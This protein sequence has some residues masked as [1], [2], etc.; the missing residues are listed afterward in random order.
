MLA[1]HFKELCV[2]SSL[3]VVASQM[4]ATPLKLISHIWICLA[5][6]QKSDKLLQV[7]IKELSLQSK[8][9]IVIYVI[10]ICTEVLNEI[11]S[12]IEALIGVQV[13]K[14]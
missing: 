1:E 11:K 13:P 6:I 7:M 8:E 10:D 5:L 4:Q 2:V 14:S 3:R 12:I 9:T